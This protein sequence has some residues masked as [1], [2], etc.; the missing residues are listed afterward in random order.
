MFFDKD[1]SWYN[2]SQR[3]LDHN[4][5]EYLLGAEWDVTDRLTVSAGAQMTRYGLTDEYM[6]D[7]SFVVNSISYGFGFNYKVA[8]HVK[9]KAG[10]FETDYENYDRVMSDKV[11]DSFTRTNRVIGIGCD[12][13]I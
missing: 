3:L 11:R 13:D 12:I 4:S 8:D 7:L 1:A 9:V 2:N 5:M 6:N 10:Y